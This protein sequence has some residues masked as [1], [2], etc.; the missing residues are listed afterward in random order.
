MGRSMKKF[1]L[2]RFFLF[3]KPRFGLHPGA[4]WGL[5]IFFFAQNLG[6]QQPD[7]MKTRRGA[8]IDTASIFSKSK[9]VTAIDSSA[10]SIKTV[11]K[12]DTLGADSMPARRTNFFTKNYPNPRKAALFSIIVPGS[13]Q[14]YNKKYWKIP[15]A[16]A[17]CGAPIYFM[18]QNTKLRNDWRRAYKAAVDGDPATVVD[19]NFEKY[20]NTTKKQA[21]DFY[22]KNLEISYLATAGAYLVVAADAFVD[23]HL[24]TFDVSD[25][26]S[27][28]ITPRAIPSLGSSATFGVGF[29]FSPK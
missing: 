24:K 28:K 11:S 5:A 27:L 26:L 16:W 29:C 9:R 22:Q 4:I 2:D 7:S 19:P 12:N 13:G 8:G 23:A 3:E 18:V 21:R 10:I 25:D 20:D 1:W 6:A 14:F 15:L 17:A